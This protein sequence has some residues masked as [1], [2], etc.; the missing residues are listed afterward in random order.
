MA[1]ELDWKSSKAATPRGFES[2]VLR[3]ETVPYSELGALFLF[4][5]VKAKS[6]EIYKK[7]DTVTITV[8]IPKCK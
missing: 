1:K 3:Q 5:V 4:L 6:I 2:H 7:H 8:N